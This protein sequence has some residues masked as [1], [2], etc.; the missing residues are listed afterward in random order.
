MPEVFCIRTKGHRLQEIDRSID[1]YTPFISMGSVQFGLFG[2]VRCGVEAGFR[3]GFSTG[4]GRLPGWKTNPT[5][6]NNNNNNTGI[7]FDRFLGGTEWCLFPRGTDRSIDRRDASV[8]VSSTNKTNE[9]TPLS[10]TSHLLSFVC[11]EG[12]TDRLGCCF[13]G[14]TER[15]RVRAS[16]SKP[17]KPFRARSDRR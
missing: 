9:R 5:N 11:N 16:A 14:S 10:R 17:T 8:R 12:V 6:A 7:G 1:R 3:I 13:L 2:S 15:K 4:N